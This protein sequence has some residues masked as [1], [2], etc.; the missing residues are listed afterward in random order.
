MVM[1]PKNNK[2]SVDSYHQSWKRDLYLIQK[3]RM[4]LYWRPPLYN[5]MKLDCQNGKH[6]SWVHLG[7]SELLHKI[8]RKKDVK[9]DV[10][11]KDA[12]MKNSI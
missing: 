5:L 3:V 9:K 8:I 2:T 11:K 10:N 12:E 1:V 7:L 6:K 4:N